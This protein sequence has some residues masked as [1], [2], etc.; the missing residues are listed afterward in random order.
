M[1]DPIHTSGLVE[2]SASTVYRPRRAVV[3]AFAWLA[4]GQRRSLWLVV[5]RQSDFHNV[6]HCGWPGSTVEGGSFWQGSVYQQPRVWVSGAGQQWVDDPRP[7][8]F[9]IPRLSIGISHWMPSRRSREGLGRGLLWSRWGE[10]K[11]RDVISSMGGSQILSGVIPDRFIYPPDFRV[12]QARSAFCILIGSQVGGLWV[13]WAQEGLRMLH[14]GT[15]HRL[16]DSRLI[17]RNRRTYIGRWPRPGHWA[18]S[19][20]GQILIGWGCGLSPSPQASWKPWMN[21]WRRCGNGRCRSRWGHFINTTRC[22]RCGVS[23]PVEA[24]LIDSQ[25]GHKNY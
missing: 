8:S 15:P 1:V 23:D 3:A 9:S 4:S 7:L 5:L 2:A 14:W 12:V 13:L 17:P 25:L 6:Q 11:S 22:R 16:A 21:F 20:A 18:G 10:A 24:I 19:Q